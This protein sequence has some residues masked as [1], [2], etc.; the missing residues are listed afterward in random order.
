MPILGLRDIQVN[1][2][3]NL[4]LEQMT[5]ATAHQNILWTNQFLYQP[6]PVETRTNPYRYQKPT[7][8]RKSLTQLSAITWPATRANQKTRNQK[9]P[10][11]KK[12]QRTIPGRKNLRKTFHSTIFLYFFTHYCYKRIFSFSKTFYLNDVFRRNGVE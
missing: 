11:S 7:I 4:Q 12:P 3:K 1:V 10:S 6:Y 9:Y 5:K 8:R 2:R